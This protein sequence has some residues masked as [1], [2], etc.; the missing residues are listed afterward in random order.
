[1]ETWICD[2]PWWTTFITYSLAAIG[3]M[4]AVWWDSEIDEYGSPE[5]SIGGYVA[6]YFL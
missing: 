5:T 4:L 1:M 3:A 2:H 6:T